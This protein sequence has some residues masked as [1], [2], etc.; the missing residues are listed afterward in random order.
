[1]TTSNSNRPPFGATKIGGGRGV[2]TIHALEAADGT[3]LYYWQDNNGMWRFGDAATVEAPGFSFQTGGLAVAPIHVARVDMAAASAVNSLAMI[4]R[5]RLL[6]IS[7]STRFGVA[8]GA[9]AALTVVKVPSGTAITAGTAMLDATMAL[10]GTADT[11]VN[12]TVHST[13][14]NR[15]LADGDSVCFRLSGT[16]TG[17]AACIGEAWFV[18]IP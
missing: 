16:L 11:N 7:A 12:G 18:P 5:Q 13:L 3:T 14:A 4:A 6:L 17:L 15:I 9:A 1:M 8:G 10:T 2:P